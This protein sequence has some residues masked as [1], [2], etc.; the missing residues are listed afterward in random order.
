MLLE[1]K[2]QIRPS[3]RK[4][5]AIDGKCGGFMDWL[6]T[7]AQAN[8]FKDLS[9]ES[10]KALAEIAISRD[11]KKREL[12]FAEGDKGHSIYLLNSGTVQLFKT[13]PDGNEI[14]IK[15]I[16]PGEVFAEVVLVEQ[17]RYP[18]SAV[19]LTDCVLFLFPRRDLHRLLERED[20]RNDF[21]AM[22]MRKQRYLAERIYDLST[23][24]VEERLFR[25]LREHYGTRTDIRLTLSKKDIAAAIGTTPE[26]LSRLIQKLSEKGVLSWQGKEIELIGD[27]AKDE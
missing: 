3:L 27:K 24:D 7:L 5:A 22:L 9:P 8:F 13:A 18:V 4:L 2:L 25:F 6:I 21:I 14:V 1:Q 16:Q 12:L 10:R 17:D 11:V 19:A 15:L 23:R 26:T 20:F